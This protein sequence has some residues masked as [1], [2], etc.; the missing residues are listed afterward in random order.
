MTWRLFLKTVTL[1]GFATFAV[2]AVSQARAESNDGSSVY[3]AAPIE[4]EI[5]AETVAAETP[6]PVVLPEAP[7]K[8]ARSG[9][10]ADRV[11]DAKRLI[12]IK[13]LIARYASENDLPVELAEAVIRLESR[14]N[15]A[16]RNGVNV[17]L[18]QIN[19]GT[20]RSMGYKGEVAGL[21]DA[22]TNLRYGLKYLAQAYKLAGGDTCGTVLRFQSGH[23]AQAMTRA[24]KSYC[25]KVQALLAQ[26]I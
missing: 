24:A 25:T 3:G 10:L 11:P 8:S 21:L 23:R 7:V 5:P 9:K 12:E 1:A 18:T 4:P 16:A 14:Y 2:A 13:P 17:G 19:A 22:E 6:A 20:A 15:A 26:A